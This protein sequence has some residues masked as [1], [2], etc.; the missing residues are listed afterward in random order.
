MSEAENAASP[1]DVYEQNDSQEL[2]FKD[3]KDGTGDVVE[4]G[5]LLTVKYEARLMASGKRFDCSPK[6]G[7][8]FRIGEGKVLPGWEKGLVVRRKLLT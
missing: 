4:N 6:D 5:K 2:A 3:V 8:V 7:Y 1:F